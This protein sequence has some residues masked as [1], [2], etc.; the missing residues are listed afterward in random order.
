MLKNYLIVFFVIF[1]VVPAYT[2][3]IPENLTEQFNTALNNLRAGN[4][5]LALKQYENLLL[6]NRIILAIPDKGLMDML[7]KKYEENSSEETPESFLKLGLIYDVNGEVKKAKI[8]Y[9]KLLDTKNPA[10]RKRAI[11]LLQALL[12]EKEFYEKELKKYKMRM[13]EENRVYQLK[14]KKER[15]KEKRAEL[16]KQV[17]RELKKIRISFKQD[18]NDAL[19]KIRK[20][21]KQVLRDESKMNDSKRDWYGIGNVRSWRKKKGD[22]PHSYDNTFR[23]RYRQD[24]KKFESSYEELK[25]AIKQYNDDYG[26]LTE[27]KIP[28]V[29]GEL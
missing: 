8:I 29:D 15:Q 1:L 24:K 16:K 17:K 28:E 26:N 22:K 6:K 13:A 18:K 20:L 19:E 21:R 11:G 5:E 10:V 2:I 23:R 14:L 27:V 3:D 9:R 25:K 4:E 7:I 12:K